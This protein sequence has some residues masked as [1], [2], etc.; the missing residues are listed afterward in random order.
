MPCP[1]SHQL[2]REP[3]DACCAVV[4]V[5]E[6]RSHTVHAAFMAAFSATHSIKVVPHA[7]VRTAGVCAKIACVRVT[8]SVCVHTRCTVSGG[9][10]E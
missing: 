1:V 5:N 10:L 6:L 4:V 2:A 9:A 3:C 8:V 7:K